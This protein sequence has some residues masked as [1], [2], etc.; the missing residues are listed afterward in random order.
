MTNKTAVITGS[1][2]GIGAEFARRFAAEGYD[3]ILTGRRAELIQ[4]LAS[5][6]TQ[7][8]GVSVET[9][10][11]ELSDEPAVADLAKKLK[12]TNVQVL[13]NN[14]GFGINQLFYEG[15]LDSYEQMVK[16]H[17]RAPM[18][19]TYAVLPGMLASGSGTIIN[20][21]SE[22]VFVPFRKNAMYT[23][24]KAFLKSFTE[25]LH[26]DLLNS[27]IRVQALCPGLTH[28]DFH[29]KLGMDKSRQRDHGMVHWMS[30][31]EVVNGSLHDLERGSVVSIPGFRTKALVFMLGLLPRRTYYRV[32]SKALN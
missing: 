17:V 15:D 7:K 19:L 14:A 5:E 23:A 6:L 18:A 12:E 10:L 1:T 26:M 29:E 2:S 32:L 24:T 21:C 9:L 22:A 16:V 13:I 3:L 28:T 8:Y 20:V 11:V 27:G 25:C 4:Q 30:P 31:E